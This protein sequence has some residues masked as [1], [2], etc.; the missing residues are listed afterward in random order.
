M[1][2]V[3]HAQ[4]ASVDSAY[5]DL[6]TVVVSFNQWEQKRNEV[7]NRIQKVDLRDIVLRNPQTAADLLGQSA[8]IFIQKSQQ[9]GGSPMIRGFAANRVLIVADG[10]RMNNAIFRSGNLQ[11]II[12]IDPQAVENAEVIMGPGT[13]LYGSDAMGV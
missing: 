12:S 8:G 3:V 11:N 10:V 13:I 1:F 5:S 2:M 4:T 7:P 9:A 6:E